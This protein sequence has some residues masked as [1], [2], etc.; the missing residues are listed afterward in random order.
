[1]T[2]LDALDAVREAR[3][4]LD[5]TSALVTRRDAFERLLEAAEALAGPF[6]LLCTPPAKA[7]DTL[8]E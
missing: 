4:L 2:A 5:R 3:V 6:L 1:M 7:M 8:H